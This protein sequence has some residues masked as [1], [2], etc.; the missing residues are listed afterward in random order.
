MSIL[1][2]ITKDKEYLTTFR[3]DIHSHPE[4]G[5]EEHR[6]SE[7]VAQQ[8]EELGIEVHRKVGKT[9]VVGVIR[10]GNGEGSIGLRADMDAL[11]MQEKGHAAWRSTIPGR[12]H[13][14]GHD[15]HTTMLLGAARH[16]A[17]T[18]NFNGTVNLI[19]QP[20]EEGVGGAE[21]MLADGLFE[22]F[23]CDVIFGLHNQ[24]QL[25]VG[26]VIVS[27][28]PSMAGGIFFEMIINGKGAH[29]ARPEESIDP[30]IIACQIV[31]ALQSIVSRQLSPLQ[32]AV[33][34][35]TRIHGG[36]A[37]NVIPQ[38]A[39]IGG[40]IRAMTN[41]SLTFMC[42][43]ALR[44]AEGIAAGFG[45][46]VEMKTTICFAPL[47][48]D[49]VHAA[50][51]ASVAGELVGEKSVHKTTVPVMGSEDF[52]FMLERVP[53]AFLRV[54]NGDSAALHNPA[55]D[56]NDDCI[57]Y[58]SALLVSLVEKQLPVGASD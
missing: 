31:T 36:D 3:R 56:F 38:T 51:A 13:A 12:M 25:P 53:G 26:N 39:T 55:Y 5:L 1:E 4:L 44:I 57:P 37:Y 21:A 29:G 48:N 15:G 2:T 9:G 18:R 33:L 35:V 52:S 41:E 45:A 42:D 46:T 32:P 6:T 22:R 11:P 58:G 16:L 43:S 8:L 17:R 19:F 30:V 28:G 10:A 49:P 14:C 34:S 24:P 50:F 7:A 20:G 27:S 23:P 40:T 54:G 47:H